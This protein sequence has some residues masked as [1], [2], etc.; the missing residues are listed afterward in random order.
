MKKILILMIITFSLTGCSNKEEE[1]K[2]EYIAMKNNLIKEEDYI[3]KDELPL[4]ITIKLNRTSSELIEYK[5][6]LNNP[7]E[8]MYKVKAMVVHNYYNE[9][10]FPSIGLFDE[11]KDLL[12]NN[13]LELKGELKT[14]ENIANMD[15]EL[16]VW[17]EYYNELGEKKEIYYK[18]T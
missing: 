6:I 8:D 3:K 12:K 10:L 14:T 16:K 5:V 18:T 4:D 2:S 11:K 13:E 7:V 1:E 9:E 17:I 15:L